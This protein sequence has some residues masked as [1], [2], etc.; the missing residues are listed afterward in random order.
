V[1]SFLVLLLR[2]LEKYR[3]LRENPESILIVI[4]VS[5]KFWSCE[6]YR[7]LRRICSH[8]GCL[9]CV[10]LDVTYGEYRT[11]RRIWTRILVV[12][13]CPDGRRLNRV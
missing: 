6:K 13:Y 4:C 3:T 1:S 11:L 2:G 8:Y 9:V 7:T 10:S 12:L 5:R